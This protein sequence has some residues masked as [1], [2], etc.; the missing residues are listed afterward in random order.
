ML[1]NP[2]ESPFSGPG[3]SPTPRWARATGHLFNLVVTD[4]GDVWVTDLVRPSLWHLTPEQVAS[5]TG[6]A[7]A[8]PLTPEIPHVRG[9]DNLE[10]I[11]AL[12]DTRLVAVKFADGTLY[13]IDLDPQAAQGR[14]ITPTHHDLATR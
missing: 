2:A 9:P 14:T 12:S 3:E 1:S 6:T 11:V 5:G 4:A 13:R 8:V 7:T 10:G